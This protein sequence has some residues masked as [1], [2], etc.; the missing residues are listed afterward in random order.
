MKI[1][2]LGAGTWGFCLASLLGSNGHDVFLWSAN[3][4][5]ARELQKKRAH[6]KLPHS[7][8]NEK[9]FVTND[10]RETLKDADFIIESVTSM[11]LRPVLEQVVAQGPVE[12][13]FIITSK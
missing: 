4:E 2:Y 1:A 10:L 11:G 13:P 5:F 9:V 12:C 6:P 3:P 7:H 8:L